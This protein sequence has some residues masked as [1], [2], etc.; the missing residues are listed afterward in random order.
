LWAA[1]AAAAEDRGAGEVGERGEGVVLVGVE[2]E[3]WEWLGVGVGG[4]GERGVG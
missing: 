2:E 4:V 1:L 3:G